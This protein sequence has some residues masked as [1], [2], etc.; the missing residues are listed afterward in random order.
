M[1]L[2][3][4]FQR[5][6]PLTNQEEPVRSEIFGTYRLESHATSLAEAQKVIDDPR[7]GRDLIPRLRE[8]QKILDKSYRTLLKAI[9]KKQ[10]ITPAAEW[11]VDN[12]HIVRAQ[13]KDIREHLPPEYYRELPKIAEGPLAGYPRVYGIAWAF[14]AHTDSRFDD[15]LLSVFLSAYQKVQPLTMGELWAIPISLRLV[16][17]ENLRRIAVQI[18][19]SQSSRFEADQIADSLLGLGEVKATTV[20]EA[21][22]SL[23]NKPIERGLAVQLLQR[24]RFQEAR[25]GA[26]L[27]HIDQQVSSS[28]QTIED[29]VTT[30]HNSQ[31]M[32][33]ITTRNIITS[34]RTMS[35]FDWPDFFEKNSVVQQILEE[36]SNFGSMDF[37]TRDF[38]RHRIE[39]LSRYS[40]FT[41]VDI[42]QQVASDPSYFLIGKG[43]LEFEEKI[44]FKSGF[45][46]RF[47]HWYKEHATFVYLGTIFLLTLVISYL[48]FRLSSPNMI[49]G[50]SQIVIIPIIFFIASEMAIACINRITLNLFGPKHLPR[51][52]FKKGI[53]ENLKTFIV[54]PTML[55]NK[56][57]IREQ[58]EQIE[59]HFLSNQDD[60]VYLALLTDFADAN[61][62]N[63]ASDR[64]I[65][66]I[67]SHELKLLNERYP[68]KDNQSPRFSIFHRRRLYNPQEE[69]WMGWERKRGKLQEFNRLLLGAT[70]T[71]FY[72]LGD[73][74]IRVPRDIHY[75]ITLDADT[76]LPR[77]SVRQLVGT[78]A[79]PLNRPHF[80]PIKG[81]VTSGYGILQPRI[82]PTLQTRQE[83]TLFRRL[84]ARRPGIDP[85]ASAV[86]DVYQDLFG[87]GSFAGKGIYDLS[88]FEKA[89][90]NRIPENAILS[91]D[92]FEGNFVRCGFLSDVEFLEDFPSHIGVATLRSHRWTRGD[93]Q[94]LPW[95]F[96]SRGKSISIIGRWKMFDNLRRSLLAPVGLLLFFVS[97]ILP[98]LNPVVLWS[99]LI[100]SLLTP[101]LIN[102]WCGLWPKR[103]N[104]P[105]F[106]H[107]YFTYE[108]FLSG[109]SSAALS[110]VLL[111]NSAWNSLDAIVRVFYR[112]GISHKK[113]LEWT[114]AAQAKDSANLN[115]LSFF[116]NMRG[117]FFLTFLGMTTLYLSNSAY[118]SF[119]LPFFTLWLLSPVVSFYFSLPPK[120]RPQRPIPAEDVK[121]LHATA[122][123]I[124][125]F[126]SDIVTAEDSFLPPDNLQLDPK[127]ELAH[128]SSPTNFGLYL[129]SILAAKDF[130]WIGICETCERVDLTLKNLMKLSR[131]KGHF[132]NWYDTRDGCPLE[133]QYISSVD[134]G[135]FVGHL[136]ALSQGCSELLT[137]PIEASS[138][139]TGILDTLSLL[140]QELLNYKSQHQEHDQAFKNVLVVFQDISTCLMDPEPFAKD[141]FKHWEHLRTQSALLVKKTKV[142][143]GDPISAEKSEIWSWCLALQNDIQSSARDLVAF[144]SWSHF[145]HL[146]LPIAFDIEIRQWWEALQK[147][148][149]QKIFLSRLPIFCSEIQQEIINFKKTGNPRRHALPELL[150]SLLDALEVTQS[151]AKSYIQK[152]KEIEK[153]CRQFIREMDFSILYDPTRKLFSIGMR[154]KESRLDP[155]YYD[156]LASEARL[157]SFIAIAKGD[158]PVSHWFHLSRNL[159]NV[160]NG[161]ALVSWSGS[162]FEYLMPSL[163]MKSPEDS[164][165]DETC[166]RV[167]HR[168]IE[169]A[170]EKDVPWGISESAYNKRDLHLTYQYSNFGLPDL[171]LKTGLGVD[172]VIAP[173]ATLLAALYEPA[174][175]AENLRHLKDQGAL[176]PYGFYE[177]VDYTESRLPADVPRAIIKAYMTHHQGMALVALTNVFKN[178]SMQRRFHADLSVQA[179]ELLLQERTPRTIGSLPD[180]EENVQVEVVKETIEHVSR[181]YHS[182]NRPV[183][184]TQLLSNG[185]YTVM[186]TSSGS[187]FSRNGDLAVTRWREDVTR[188]NYGSYLYIKDC[189]KQNVW[190]AGHQPISKKSDRYEVSFSE[191]RARIVR[192]DYS[193]TSELEVFVSPEEN[194]EVRRLTLT[195]QGNLS[196]ELEV[197]SYAEIVLNTQAADLAHPAFSNLF[198]ETEFNPDLSTLIASRRPRSKKDKRL[199]MM[200]SILTDKC[201]TGS[202]QYETDRSLF[203]GRGR[204]VR[205]PV[206]IFDN[207]ELS[208]RIG[209]VLDPIASLRTRIRLEPG[210]SS[211]LIF[212]YG[213]AETK[214][215][216]EIMAEKYHDPAIFDRTSSLAWTQAQVKLHHLG[217]EPDEAHLFQRL[218]TRL[219][220]SDPSLRA[221]SELISKNSRSLN[222]LW[223]LGISG[224]HPIFLVQ[225]DDIE[226]RNLIRQL[227]KAQ[228]YLAT[229]GFVADLVI[230]NEKATSYAQELQ[231][232]LE[233]LAQ[234]AHAP[235]DLSV[236]SGKAFVLR[237]DL[238]SDADHIMLASEA[239]AILSTRHGSLSDQVKRTRMISLPPPKEL[240]QMTKSHSKSGP[241]IPPL[242]FFNSYGGFSLSGEEYIIVLKDKETTPAP[243]INII[244]NPNFGFQVSESGAGYTWSANSRENQIT[245]W[246]NDPICDPSGEAFFIRDRDSDALWCP[247]ASPIRHTQSTY[248]TR[249]GQGYS[250]F[251][252]Y[253]FGIS[254][255]LTQ[256]VH[257]NEPVKISR[258]VLENKTKKKRSLSVYSYV[259]WVLGFTRSIMAPTTMTEFD[260]S[261]QSIFSFNPRNSEHGKKIAF[262]AVLSGHSFFTCD[263]TEFIGRNSGLDQPVGPMQDEPLQGAI[264]GGLDPCTAFEKQIEIEPGEKMEIVFIL[265]QAEDRDSAREI[266]KRI[267]ASDTVVILEQVKKHWQ[268]LLCKIQIETPDRSFDLV[269]NRWY[270]YQTIVCRLWARAAFYQAGGAFGFRD[271]LQDVMA[272]VHSAPQMARAQILRAAS[273]QFLEGDVQHWWHPPTGRGVRTHFSDDLLW[274]PYVVSHYLKTTKDF[275][276]LKE[277]VSFI[278]GPALPADKEDSYFIPDETSQMATL[279]EHCARALDYSLKTGQHGLPLMGCGDWNDGMNHVGM[280]GK[281]ESVWLAWFL[282]TNL[283]N[284]TVYAN[285]CGETERAKVWSKHASSLVEAIEKEAWD[286]SWYKRAFFDDGTPLGTSKGLECKIDSLAQTWAV[287][288]Q[289][290]QPERAKTAMNSVYKQLVKPESK[291]ILLFTPPFDK[292]PLD[293]GYIKGY[294]PGVRE[295]GGQYTHAGSWVVIAS[296]LLGENKKAHELFSYLNPIHHAND[297][298]EANRYK[299]E[300]Y[301]LAGDVYSESHNLGRGGWSWYTGAAGWMYRA[302]I[303]FILG[304]QVTGNEL[305]LKPCVPPEWRKFKIRYRFQSSTYVIN[306]ELTSD[307]VIESKSLN[308]IDDGQIHQINW[309]F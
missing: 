302:G 262:N 265:G 67:A 164:L 140:N 275:S 101:A 192:E 122:R 219:L 206:A 210:E 110:F 56:S 272:V 249:H 21:I 5:P 141:P 259:E 20:D 246:S 295:N 136:I 283:Q 82:T 217:I 160:G 308:M 179:T 35:A 264:G 55:T 247:T 145:K 201:S 38:Y 309:I 80:D 298:T 137:S 118:L 149:D 207:D 187:G 147:K 159:V 261:S 114:T 68:V 69:K 128:R 6:L 89:M 303:E 49:F 33:N 113:L 234:T 216:I 204:S 111:P 196:R 193:I 108:E 133:P 178:S 282:F 100:V 129:L 92:L 75:V 173:Y 290:G 81:R 284:F 86:S 222:A 117:T 172:L 191:D 63:L 199:W 71:S 148:L 281:G 213:I 77:G 185:K 57:K 240:K 195:N 65:I 163:V 51:L 54:V 87:E 152:I 73:N 72:S 131:H 253:A 279:F 251:T 231:T 76:K 45:R 132:F 237:S 228:I 127:P 175:A 169:Y 156:L 236:T 53:P 48:V 154:V 142:F 153:M 90:A 220:Y 151:Q 2:L 106:H 288:S 184:T 143:C 19:N 278:D 250:C 167:I 287:I 1:Q 39:E 119:I 198:V 263:R 61:E 8:N 150:D 158:V 227:L 85:Y 146:D 134:N 10:A 84:T 170:K 109:V 126:F 267:K 83:N 289:A 52:E 307:S 42:A 88:A 40:S 209:P 194:A 229:K 29:L 37:T 98:D 162:M 241:E 257:L 97:G 105:L 66:D 270:L 16:L 7:L 203:I 297:N 301:V 190:S 95:I 235:S 232:T 200:H 189:E 225:I 79:H 202:I 211:H 223:S 180:A 305:S 15:Q 168:Q 47:L 70:D 44:Q 294:L 115:L 27:H 274:L 243:W 157:T 43:A 242:E 28:G 25:V 271:Q 30:E 94:L 268:E 215:A 34:S 299:I 306:A 291:M 139:N 125:R 245:P 218:T 212:S 59:V 116:W 18:V 103:L 12:F 286:G 58:L 26:L 36:G 292:T 276:I 252:T 255:E 186:L 174:L 91:H 214:E 277:D 4:Y 24:L 138:L 269:L 254:S 124:W 221:P 183:P 31:S 74:K 248:V 96:G 50:V 244:A 239:R 238:L 280:G 93:W 3:E 62:E 182:V 176:G 300:P 144:S 161:T 78:I 104:N 22:K 230:L 130:G 266:I 296:A 304:L 13:L 32:A 123:R 135:N 11:L 17:T 60:N 165:L 121:L 166:R 23:Q 155:S 258:L 205:N 41:E 293:P 99:F 188:D 208:G 107:L 260:E 256:F 112:M 233:N 171:G 197:T 273:R 64:Q 285:Q 120:I 46:K 177:A 226:H 181:V 102:L 9:E 14:V 224:D